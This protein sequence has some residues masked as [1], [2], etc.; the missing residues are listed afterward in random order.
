MTDSLLHATDQGMTFMRSI[1]TILLSA[2]AFVATNQLSA[3]EKPAED[4]NAPTAPATPYWD[5]KTPAVVDKEIIPL[6]PDAKELDPT[7]SD[8]KPILHAPGD[9]S[10]PVA[11]EGQIYAAAVPPAIAP[12]N[13]VPAA[14]LE[15]LRDPVRQ[16]MKILDL[17][18]QQI[19][20]RDWDAGKAVDVQFDGQPHTIRL[21][22]F[23]LRTPDCQ[24]LIQDE[25]GAL[26][27][28]ALP[29]PQTYRGQVID[30][31]NSQV[32]ASIIDGK[33]HMTII[34]ADGETWN[35][36]PIGNVLPAEIIEP[37]VHVVYRSK[38]SVGNGGECG[39]GKDGFDG[40]VF[41]VVPPE[42]QGGIAGANPNV[43]CQIAFDADFEFYQLKGSSVNNTVADI[44]MIMNQVGLIY[45]NQVAISYAETGIIV[46][47]SEPDPYG[48]TNANTLLCQFQD[49]WNS[50]VLFITRD[51]AHLFTGKDLQ[52]STIGLAWIGA[53]CT[54]AGNCNGGSVA[55]GLS[56]ST[57]TNLTNRTQLTAHE[58]GHNWNACH[59]NTGGNCGGGA[60]NPVCGIMTS[61]ISGQ[62]NFDAAAITAITGWR[63]SLTC[64]QTWYNPIHVN[65][66]WNGFEDGHIS[67]PYNTI[68]EGLANALVGGEVHAQA[69]NYFQNLNINK[70]LTIRA[71]N[72]TVRIGN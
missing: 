57:D 62:L 58:L 67:T 4:P 14:L 24:L 17:T 11:D 2:S 37:D 46:R 20:A 12:A 59:C 7:T 18:L 45:Q 60:S 32:A 34:R 51:V 26:M 50:D 43:R 65:W 56:Q 25:T 10:E 36:Q 1:Q 8:E 3:Q 68:A 48:A 54:N 22:L 53:V 21:D 30:E 71:F 15:A 16:S 41:D 55:Y 66:A 42:N 35:V 6:S 38:D 49:F 23:T 19:E 40:Q 61:G 33:L 72:G 31:L 69:G 39:I 29:A 47:T 63:D 64:L 52:G 27:P 28:M 13:P 44:E 70:I 5:Y 9:L